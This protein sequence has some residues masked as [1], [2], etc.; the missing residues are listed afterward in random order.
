MKNI[1]LQTDKIK[2]VTW[3]NNLKKIDYKW[4]LKM[5]YLQ[6]KRIHEEESAL[7]HYRDSYTL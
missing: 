1:F 7:E 6:I 2:L 5:E 4:K 3:N